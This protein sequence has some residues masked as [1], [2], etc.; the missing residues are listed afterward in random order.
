[1]QTQGIFSYQDSAKSDEILAQSHFGNRS[2]NIAIGVAGSPGYDLTARTSTFDTISVSPGDWCSYYIEIQMRDPQGALAERGPPCS[3]F[4]KPIR[5]VAMVD[6]AAGN[7]LKTF[8]YPFP[9]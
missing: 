3:P 9:I 2:L 1:M 5:I 7:F 8:K 4:K 6:I